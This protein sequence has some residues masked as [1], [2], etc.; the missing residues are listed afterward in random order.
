ML[1]IFRTG[2]SVLVPLS[3]S[4]VN[5][6]GWALEW[7]LGLSWFLVSGFLDLLSNG[8]TIG[9]WLGL[10]F[11]S[12]W[13]KCFKDLEVLVFISVLIGVIFDL[14]V[15][16]SPGL[17]ILLIFLSLLLL[18]LISVLTG[19][20]FLFLLS[21]FLLLSKLALTSVLT[22]VEGSAEGSCFPIPGVYAGIEDVL[23][24]FFRRYP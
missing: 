8:L 6:L 12:L 9:L 7:F 21:R 14:W 22:R 18:V 5:N 24:F 19:V 1:S 16:E 11:L 3:W 20:I 17:A 4:L 2:I 10:A 13:S 23:S 15:D